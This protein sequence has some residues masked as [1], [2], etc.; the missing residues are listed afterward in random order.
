MLRAR[1]APARFDKYV[2]AA[3]RDPVLALHL[4]EWNIRASASLHGA[5]GQF[6]VLL[7]NALDVQ[8]SK[9]HRTVLG[10]DGS[11]WTD[12]TMLFRSIWRRR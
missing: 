7:R 6:E 5:I 12:S 3:G 8:L 11:W 2:A 9:Y 10:G 4:Y 1:F